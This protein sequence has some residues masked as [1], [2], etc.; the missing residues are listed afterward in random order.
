MP[1]FSLPWLSRDDRTRSEPPFWDDVRKGRA[2]FVLR[3]ALSLAAV[4]VCLSAL[5][6]FFGFIEAAGGRVNDGLAAG[7]FAVAAAVWFAALAWLWATYPR[8]RRFLR[9]L[10]AVL[11]VWAV[12]IPLCVMIEEVVRRAE[13]LI[14][15]SI[16]MAIGIT[17]TLIGTA[18]YRSLGGRPLEDAAGAICVTCPG[19]GY[20]M[21][22]LPSCQCPECGRAYTIDQL[23]RGQDYAVLRTERAAQT[24]EGQP[25]AVEPPLLPSDVTSA[26]A[27]P[28]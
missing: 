14:T 9:T 12:T 26:S 20:S 1:W 5:M 24:L 28:G 16:F 13:F 3:F 2:G 8:W 17:I 4:A 22:G 18:A 21:V 23:I 27:E 6:F 10:F 7:G 11:T 19:C 25:A 15:G